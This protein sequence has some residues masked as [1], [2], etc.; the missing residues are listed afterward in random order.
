MINTIQAALAPYYLYIKFVHVLA[1]MA[2]IWSTAVAY[3]F[4]L[5]PIFK[6]WRRNPQDPEIREMR[7]W[8]LERFD[9]GVSYEHI[10]FPVILVTGVLLYITAGFNTSINW[11]L[12]KLLI[13]TGIL[14]PIEVWDYHL[15]HFG[16]NKRR[17]RES[18]AGALAYEKAVHQ[19]WWFLL[20]TS[21]TVMIFGILVV[22]LAIS[23][24]F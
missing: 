2:W 13:V 4:Y 10:A 15:S 11:L 9:H 16:G 6:A 14:I 21:P 3:A 12:L 1:V 20:L 18:G 7:N 22:F 23:K 24:P 5:V 8:A 17:I 19:H